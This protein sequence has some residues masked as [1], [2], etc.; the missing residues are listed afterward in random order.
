MK[1]I[2]TTPLSEEV[3]RDLRIGDVVYLTGTFAT[4]RDAGHA[5]VLEEKIRPEFDLRNM[6]I[7]HTGPIV[8]KDESGYHIVSIGP[9][10]SMRME[11][12]EAEFIEETGIRLIIGKGGMGQATTDACAKYG[13]VHCVVPGGCAV[14]EADAVKRV[15]SAEWLDLG[16]PEAFYV[17]EAEALGPLIVSID[18]HGG[19]LFIQNKIDFNRRRD[20]QA[21]RLKP[22]IHFL[23]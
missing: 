5:R 23:K 3:I 20:E 11:Q 15:A 21:K 2:I 14:L 12:L 13:A 8:R 16:M 17:C 7:F 22:K 6:A 9:T 4:C 18:T 19:N 1:K 10:T